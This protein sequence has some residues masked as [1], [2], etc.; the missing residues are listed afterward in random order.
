MEQLGLLLAAAGEGGAGGAGGVGGVSGLSSAGALAVVEAAEVVKA[1]ADSVSIEATTVMVARFEAADLAPARPSPQGWARFVRHCRSAVAHEI[2][3]ATGLPIT[4]C[5][6]RVWFAACEPERVGAIQARMATGRVSFARAATL[7]EATAHLDAALAAGIAARVLRPLTGP[8][9][10]PSAGDPVLSQATFRARLH[11]QLV[12]HHGLVGATER[13]YQQALGA[14]NLWGQP[15]HDGTGTLL[16]T[17]DGTKI[18]AAIARLDAL[19]RQLRHRGDPRDPGPAQGRPGHRP[20]D[21]RHQPR[22]PHLRAPGRPGPGP[23]PAD[24]LAEHP[25]GPPRR[26]RADPRLGRGPSRGRPGPRPWPPDR[27]GPGW[28]PTR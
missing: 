19:A 13:T 24:R 4:A 3:V 15:H 28:S 17:G 11:T 2:Q 25:A 9:G 21:P 1:W 27:S 8:D 12:L 7:A 14:R 26:G 23:R 16:L 10:K 5:Q 20:V 18:S 22:Q 6:R